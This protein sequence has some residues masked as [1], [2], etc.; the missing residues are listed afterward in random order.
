MRWLRAVVLRHLEP[1]MGVFEYAYACQAQRPL[2]VRSTQHEA[3]S[4]L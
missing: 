3:L 1:E 2:C 4:L